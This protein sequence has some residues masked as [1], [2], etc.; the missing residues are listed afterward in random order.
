MVCMHPWFSCSLGLHALCSLLY[1]VQFVNKRGK[2]NKI[3]K[4]AC[5]AADCMGLLSPNPALYGGAWNDPSLVPCN[6]MLDNPPWKDCW[7]FDQRL[8]GGW[9]VEG[10]QNILCHATNLSNYSHFKVCLF[11]VNFM[12]CPLAGRRI[13]QI[14]AISDSLINF[15]VM[16]DF[17]FLISSIFYSLIVLAISQLSIQQSR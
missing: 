1:W 16:I 14:I 2:V 13:P 10:F 9:F 3:I 7:V 4:I 11:L 5:R 6:C 15:W 12:K 17:S 8:Y